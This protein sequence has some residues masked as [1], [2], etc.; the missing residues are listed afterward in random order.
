[1]AKTL[2]GDAQAFQVVAAEAC[3]GGGADAGEDAE[4]GVRR[5]IAGGRGAGDM[6]GLLGDAV[7]VG[8][9]GAAVHRSD[10]AAVEGLDHAPEGFEQR[11]AV[12]HMGRA[13]DHCLAATLV[14]TGQG[15]GKAVIIMPW[16]RR[17]ASRIAL[18]SSG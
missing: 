9:G 3:M 16:A 11:G 17:M 14:E 18:S 4:G 15:G 12:I 13:D 10:V 6:A 8:A 7:H 5:R 1:M 2:H